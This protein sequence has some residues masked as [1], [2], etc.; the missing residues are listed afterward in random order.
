MRILK[1]RSSP[2]HAEQS[3]DPMAVI[4]CGGEPGAFDLVRTLGKAGIRSTVFSS[5]SDDI[6][7]RSKYARRP[8]LILPEFRAE[9]YGEIFQRIAAFSQT[10][11]ER[12]VLLY[13]GDSELMFVSMF[14][15]KLEPFY[16]FLLPPREILESLMSKVAFIQ[17]AQK[18]NLPV[19]P[20]RGFASVSELQAANQTID[21]PCIVKP[22]YN[23]DW[24]WQSE[25]LKRRFGTY[26]Q[27]LRRFDSR[28][29]LLEFCKEIPET[30]SGFVVQSYIDGPDNSIACFHGYFDEH[31]VC[32]GSFLT[33][34][35]RTNPPCTGDLAC[36]ETFHDGD[37]A[38]LSIEYLQRIRFQ[39][40]VKI[41][42]KWDEAA[43]EHK[44]LEIEP[45]YQAWHLLGAY[46]GVNLA[47]IAYRHQKGE[48]VEPQTEYSDNTQLLYLSNDLKAYW[49]GY[50][51]NR[52]WTCG[53]YLKSLAKKKH[54]RIFDSADPMP[55]VYAT[56]RY[57][58][59]KGLRLAGF[60]SPRRGLK[61]RPRITRITR[62]HASG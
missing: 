40:V 16:R 12:P 32:L 27:A 50:R 21:L 44:V 48:R 60:E 2:R 5:R 9:N 14:R 57:L 43:R 46:A 56:Y 45:H 1:A 19:P 52:E 4:M 13:A 23:Q 38:G 22:A 53:S 20:A 11:E 58:A 61:T 31:S 42:Y 41:D 26:K 55:F 6:A 8:K 35:I 7:F 10:C 3:G 18:M 25:A 59:R 24:F 30:R 34:E 37:L 29:A 49:H 62:K 36:C 51:K 39:G 47:A 15:E 17:F 33:R 28:P 54:F